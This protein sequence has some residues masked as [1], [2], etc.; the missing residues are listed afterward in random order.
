MTLEEKILL[1]TACISLLAVFITYLSVRKMSKQVEIQK[2]QWEYSQKPIFRIID[3]VDTESYRMSI[4]IIENSNNIFHIIESITFT[5]PDVQLSDGTQGY[6]KTTSSITRIEE[7]SE[8]LS[9]SLTPK[10][11]TFIEGVIQIKGVD[12]LGNNF[13]CNSPVIK[14]NQLKTVNPRDF[15]KIYF[16]FV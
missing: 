4:L 9:V 10:V 14:F 16:K 11:N 5:T 6:I 8:G 12:I 7:K 1:A 13:T 2:N 15:K 3:H